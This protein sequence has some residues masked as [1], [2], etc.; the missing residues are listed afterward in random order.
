MEYAILLLN[1]LSNNLF[2]VNNAKMTT[3]LGFTGLFSNCIYKE[4]ACNIWENVS[5]TCFLLNSRVSSAGNIYLWEKFAKKLAILLLPF[6]AK[7]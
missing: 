3:L 4:I 7:T 5:V 2:R 6:H 1:K